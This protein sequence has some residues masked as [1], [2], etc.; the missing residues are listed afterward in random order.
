MLYS[1]R[2]Y[3]QENELLE[4]ITYQIGDPCVCEKYIYSFIDY[5]FTMLVQRVAYFFRK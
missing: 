1:V 3:F 4:H 5:L 2:I